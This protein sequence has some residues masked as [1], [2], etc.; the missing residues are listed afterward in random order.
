MSK[1]I[2][3]KK[4]LEKEL[5][6][7]YQELNRIIPS[8]I[9]NNQ[10]D[11]LK[12]CKIINY[13]ASKD[14]FLDVVGGRIVYKLRRA[15]TGIADIAIDGWQVSAYIDT[16]TLYENIYIYINFIGNARLEIK[17]EIDL[18]EKRVSSIKLYV[19]PGSYWP[20]VRVYGDQ[21]LN[22]YVDDKLDLDMLTRLATLLRIERKKLVEIV[23]K[24]LE[25]PIDTEDIETIETKVL[26]KLQRVTMSPRFY[27]PLERI[28]LLYTYSLLPGIKRSED[29]FTNHSN[30]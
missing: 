30:R 8:S 9:D 14:L 26:D 6:E 11:L 25:T 21:P 12:A 10:H 24:V 19:P 16:E 15:T 1:T 29:I 18:P 13:V 22:I 28:T 2:D 27:L 23:K 5:I 20:V 7:L 4:Q 17:I 3:A